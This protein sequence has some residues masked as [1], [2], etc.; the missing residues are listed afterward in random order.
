VIEDALRES[1]PKGFGSQVQ[2]YSENLD[3]EW[4]SLR[5]Y[6]ASEAE[7][8]RN[9]YS[10]RNIKVIATVSAPASV[11]ATEFHD[12]VFPGIPVVLIAVPE[13]RVDPASIPSY[14]VGVFEDL[15]PTPTLQLALRLHP[16]A[17]RLVAI[18]GAY[19]TESSWDKL[20]RDA[21]E[22]LGGGLEV[23]YLSGL[24]T[25]DVLQRVAAL[26]RGTIVFTGGYFVDGAGN[27]FTSTV[28]SIKL[29]AQASAVPVY[30]AYD[31]QL[32]TGI[33]GGYMHRFEDEGRAGG[34]MIVRLLKG[35][36]PAEVGW[37]VAARV[38][39][40]D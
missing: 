25:A 28:Q 3:N 2:L 5:K 14:A 18:R 37:S 36:T 7:F 33:V 31:S 17:R 39:I 30:G 35:A 4:A 8:L 19:E 27:V 10:E 1:V 15:D 38:P 16:D 24:P 9:K 21:V 32:G 29:I 23:E 13:I 26:S 22:R 6:G 12:R 40:V 11:F 20:V 34:A